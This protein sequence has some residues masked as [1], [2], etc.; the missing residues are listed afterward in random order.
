MEFSEPDIFN[1]STLLLSEKRGALYVGAREAIF[2]LSKKNVSVKNS[3]VWKGN[4]DKTAGKRFKNIFLLFLISFPLL[5]PS[6]PVDSHRARH[7]HV[8]AE[9]KIERGEFRFSHNTFN[10]V[11]LSTSTKP[12]DMVFSLL[13][14]S[15]QRDC[16]NYIRVLQ[17]LDDERLYVCGTNAFQPQCEYVVGSMSSPSSNCTDKYSGSPSVKCSRSFRR[18]WPTSR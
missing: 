9:R 4:D 7:A 14:V 16:L 17:V 15:A 6:G 13:D 10:P 5:S 12:N 11:L 3:E 2:E 1:Y 8:L 18:T